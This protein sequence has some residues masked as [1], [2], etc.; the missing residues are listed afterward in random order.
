MCMIFD[1]TADANADVNSNSSQ[2]VCVKTAVWLAAD[3]GSLF[4]GCR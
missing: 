1:I 2:E 3:V 4:N